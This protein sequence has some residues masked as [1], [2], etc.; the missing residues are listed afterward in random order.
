[1]SAEFAGVVELKSWT[2]VHAPCSMCLTRPA[3]QLEMWLP[4]HSQLTVAG[5]GSWLASLQ[6]IV[7]S[8]D[9][10]LCQGGKPE[11]GRA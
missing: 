1:M 7:Y 11:G 8:A 6:A 9:G 5:F 3:A 2:Y 4:A 10:R